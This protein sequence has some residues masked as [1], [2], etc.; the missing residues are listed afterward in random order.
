MN[1]VTRAHSA[2]GTSKL[3]RM[4]FLPST[5]HDVVTPEVTAASAEVAPWI[6]ER[7]VALFSYAIS[8]ENGSLVCSVHF[9]KILI[10]S[11]DEP[12]SPQ[13]TENEQ[14]LIDWGRLI[15]RNPRGIP[16]EFSARLEAAFSPERRL[17]LLVL[18]GQLLAAN[19][20]TTVG[21]MP[22]DA[23][24]YPYRKPGDDRLA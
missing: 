12:D 17:S 9:R 24:L 22:L 7:A 13:L 1:T 16:D 21:R 3:K 4:T 10:D 14:L 8:D 19:L 6:G 11:G 15:A 20:I 18:A 2:V 23:E 5:F